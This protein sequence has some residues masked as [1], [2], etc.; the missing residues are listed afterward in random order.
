MSAPVAFLRG[1]THPIPLLP[2]TVFTFGRG[3]ENSVYLK[4]AL[5]SRRHAAV[6][7]DKKG[8]IFVLDRGSSNKTFVNNEAI[9][10]NKKI[11][12][13]H[14]DKIRIGGKVIRLVMK[15]EMEGTG[16]DSIEN[17]QKVSR[18]GNIMVD[19]P[20]AGAPPRDAKFGTEILTAI[21]PSQINDAEQEEL[22]QS[23]EKAAE[24]QLKRLPKPPKVPG[25]TFE[26]LYRP[27]GSVSGD[28][29]DFFEVS[30]DRLAVVM[31]DVSG[32]GVEAAL[33]VNMIRK[34]IKI[35]A[36]SLGSPAETL[37]ITN[38]DIQEDLGKG[39]FCS[40]FFA[41]VNIPERKLTFSRAGHSPLIVFNPKRESPLSLLEPKGLA[42][43][44]DKGKVFNRILEEMELELMDG[45]MLVQFTDGLMEAPNKSGEQFGMKRICDTVE[46]YG[47]QK[48][49]HLVQM[50]NLMLEKHCGGT[51]ADDDLTI[52]CMKVDSEDQ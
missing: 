25:I 15:D 47:H 40:I 24:Q 39:T 50:L 43:G 36:R 46:R 1:F 44:L 21:T 33:S 48:A 41:L 26:V 5:V 35:H 22:L 14:D 12:L 11:R 32:H 9:E 23:I 38:T 6:S 20:G 13:K 18:H 8:E 17:A 29:Y 34:C 7:C 16:V 3:K 10:P 4:D 37:K 2:G 45:D 52:L 19:V 51:P 31:G 30:E 49:R 42:V 28:F 27:L